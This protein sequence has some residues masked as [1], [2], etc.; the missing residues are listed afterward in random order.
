MKKQLL[1]LGFALGLSSMVS[2]ASYSVT[3][4]TGGGCTQNEETAATMEF[5]TELDTVTQQGTVFAKWVYK[6]PLE[7]TKRINCQVMYDNEVTKQSMELDRMRMEI[8]LLKKQ[9]NSTNVPASGDD[10]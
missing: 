2:A 4:S 9:L 8:A 1:L 10:W 5:G 6:V 3:T 7:D